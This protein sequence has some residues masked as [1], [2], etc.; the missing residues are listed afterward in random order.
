MKRA[1]AHLIDAAFNRYAPTVH[2]RSAAAFT[3][4]DTV[5]GADLLADVEE[6]FDSLPPWQRGSHNQAWPDDLWAAIQRHPAGRLRPDETIDDYV[7]AGRHLF[8][9]PVQP[10]DAGV[11]PDIDGSQTPAGAEAMS[12]DIPPSV[13]AASAT[14]AGGPTTETDLKV[15]ISGVLADCGTPWATTTA[16]ILARELAL[17]F[18]ITNK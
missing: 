6:H 10:V 17:R 1:I 7:R 5:D 16:G 12:P 8:P 11:V 9:V 14:G 18:H 13:V 2:T 4:D 15:A 3:T